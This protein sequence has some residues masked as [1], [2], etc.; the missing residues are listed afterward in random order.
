M[1]MYVVPNQGHEVNTQE[2]KKNV[3]PAKGNSVSG[4]GKDP[5]IKTDVL[6]T[7]TPGQDTPDPNIPDPNAENTPNPNAPP[8]VPGAS[9]DDF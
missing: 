3:L 8:V 1:P 4:K 2:S 7:G 5:V 6:V 9:L